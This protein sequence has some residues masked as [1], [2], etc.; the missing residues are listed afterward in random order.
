LASVAGNISI[1]SESLQGLGG[2]VT[3]LYALAGGLMS[4]SGGLAAVAL[5]GIMAIPIFS[6]LGGL[7]AITPTLEG[8]GSLFGGDE[9]SEPSTD[10]D[11]SLITE[12][13]ALGKE[14]I[15][16]RRD[17]QSQP[18]LINVDGKVVSKISRVQSRQVSSKNG[19]GG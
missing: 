2:L 10:G 19:F 15:G 14:L 3:P 4:I 7:A 17:I 11:S 16:M 5:A 6:A 12:I 18:I 9:S 13:K 8:L 1:I